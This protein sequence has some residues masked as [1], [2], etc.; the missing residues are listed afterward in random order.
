MLR[1]VILVICISL[2]SLQGYA[3]GIYGK[4]TDPKTVIHK[5]DKCG[6]VG[7]ALEVPCYLGV[8]YQGRL[9][10]KCSVE[11]FNK[12]AEVTELNRIADLQ[13][14]NNEKTDN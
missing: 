4:I 8:S 2:V 3:V 12:E 13:K 9:C 14:E 11:F 5:C 6:K 7:N 10:K 1:S